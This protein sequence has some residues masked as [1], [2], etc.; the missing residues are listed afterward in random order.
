MTCDEVREAFSDFYDN[1]LSGPPLAALTRHLK[2]CPAC[3]MEWAAFQRAV[4]AVADLGSAEPS[5][6]FAAR[7]RHRLEAP[8][9][10]QRVLHWLF[11]PLRVKAPLQALALVLVAFAGLL[12]YQRSP[13]LRREAD[14]GVASPPPV[15][16]DAPPTLP[17]P[18]APPAADATARGAQGVKP[19]ADA[20]GQMRA[21]RQAPPARLEAEEERAPSPLREEAK[22][23][24]KGAAPPEIPKGAESARELRGESP[25]PGVAGPRLK[26][27]APAPAQS[28]APAKEGQLSAMGTGS[29]DELYSTA[30]KDL[31]RQ[32]YDRAIDGLRSFVAQHPR[33]A[34]VPDARFR[35]AEAYFTRQRYAE[36]IPE[37]EALTR[38]F[39]DSPLVPTALLRQGQARLALGDPTGCQVLG[40]VAGRYPRAPEAT[41]AREVLSTRC[42]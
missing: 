40:D 31:A 23:M 14:P 20:P 5:P 12:I 30:L 1:T 33:D 6:G 19:R 13:D 4:R 7:V 24:G 29:A 26:A 3:G 17:T 37:Y 28:P 42:P 36:A 8:P 27:S 39:P 32:E 15:A 25:E 22:G 9:W 10:W 35:L 34:R 18:A 16:R 2:T 11:L 38:E 41:Q 21:E